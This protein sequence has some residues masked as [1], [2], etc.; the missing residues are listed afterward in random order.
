MPI[1]MLQSGNFNIEQHRHLEISWTN[2]RYESCMVD[3][4]IYIYR[5][6]S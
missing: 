1:N 5:V 3:P 2:E 4:L 6:Y